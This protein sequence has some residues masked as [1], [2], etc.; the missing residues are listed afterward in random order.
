MVD[1]TLNERSRMLILYGESRDQESAS[2][3]NIELAHSSLHKFVYIPFTYNIRFLK[4][5]I[6]EIRLCGHDQCIASL[7]SGSNSDSC[8]LVQ[9]SVEV[10]YVMA[11]CA[12][13]VES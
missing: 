12:G 3:G 2:R 8:Q 11:L 9:T 10:I 13:D 4:P 5:S 1:T 7:R 6:P